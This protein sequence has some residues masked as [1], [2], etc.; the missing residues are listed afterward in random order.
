MNWD[1][2]SPQPWFGSLAGEESFMGC[3]DDNND[4]DF[5]TTTIFFVPSRFEDE[6]METEDNDEDQGDNDDDEMKERSTSGH[7]E[8]NTRRE[9][10]SGVRPEDAWQ[11]TPFG[12]A[13]QHAKS[14]GVK[15]QSELPDA[16]P[17]RE[18]P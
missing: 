16:P 9:G 4:L 2:V 3:R 15:H 18:I 8:G 13:E 7:D 12:V 6:T 17:A 14:H 5:S 10:V 11:E 1:F